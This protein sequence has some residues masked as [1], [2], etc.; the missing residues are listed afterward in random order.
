MAHTQ[1]HFSCLSIP[2]QQHFGFVEES[3]AQCESE[4][5]FRSGSSGSIKP[6]AVIELQ[7]SYTPVNFICDEARAIILA[8]ENAANRRADLLVVQNVAC[9]ESIL[10]STF[11]PYE[12]ERVLATSAP[13][14]RFFRTFWRSVTLRMLRLEH[15]KRIALLV[16]IKMVE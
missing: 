10:P 3:L 11:D 12:P 6:D 1:E 8:Y 14:K 16:R 5:W 15:E 9:Q 2:D 7:E 13:P 4:P